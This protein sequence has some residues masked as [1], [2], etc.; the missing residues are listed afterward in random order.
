MGEYAKRKGPSSHT[1]A[2]GMHAS[3]SIILELFYQ[4]LPYACNI[5][6]IFILLS[7]NEV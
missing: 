6:F 1:K 4:Y 5:S 3:L 7:C 2:C